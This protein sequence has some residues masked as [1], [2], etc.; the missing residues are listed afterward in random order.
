[1]WT[2]RVG[3]PPQAIGPKPRS[4]GPIAEAFRVRLVDRVFQHARRCRRDFVPRVL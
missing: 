2:N 1:M 3:H 4:F